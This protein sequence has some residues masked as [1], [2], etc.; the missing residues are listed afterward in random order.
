MKA[1]T[2]HKKN[3]KLDTI[4]RIKKRILKESCN[5]DTSYKTTYKDIKKYFKIF[6]KALFKD[7]LNPFN[8]IQIKRMNGCWGQC[9]EDYS[10]RKGTRFFCLEMQPNYENKKEFLTTLGHEMIHL[11]QQTI[12][13]DTGNHNSLFYSFR[14]RFK[15]LGLSL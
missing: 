10:L 15:K 7:Q 9:V 1:M 12:K 11:W 5:L 13:K 6:N 8:D 2:I 14:P 4:V 3:K